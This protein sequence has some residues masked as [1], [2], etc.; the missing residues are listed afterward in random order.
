MLELQLS[1]ETEQRLKQVLSMN[2]NND[3][4]F[5]KAIDYQ[6]NEL[7]KGIFNIEKD[8]KKFEEKY[9]LSSKLFYEKFENGEFGDEDDYMIWAGIYEMYLNDTQKLAKL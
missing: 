4:F 6:V 9:N 2:A 3:V 5:N 1:N 8:L 7:K